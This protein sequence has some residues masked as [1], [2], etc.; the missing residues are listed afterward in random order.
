MF[1]DYAVS[2]DL[3]MVDVDTG[4]R[5][6]LLPTYIDGTATAYHVSGKAFNKPGW[7]VLSTYANY[8][9]PEK[10]L[11]QRVMA[12]ELKAN[13]TIINLAHHH[14]QYNAYWTEPHASVNRDLTKVL[15][16]SNWGTTSDLDVDAYLIRLPDGLLSGTS[17]RAAAD[18]AGARSGEAAQTDRLATLM[19]WLRKGARWLQ[20][21]LGSI[22]R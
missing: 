6:S 19:T 21:L 5:T 7:I 17:T 13:P 8:G 14:S 22:F 18:P 4:V 16:N 20:G 9:G 12:V 15:F 3:V 11:H 10:W 2:G 1:T